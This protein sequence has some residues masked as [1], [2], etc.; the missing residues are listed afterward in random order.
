MLQNNEMLVLRNDIRM[1]ADKKQEYLLDKR[2]VF[3]LLND[4]LGVSDI[5]N[6][7]VNI[8]YD[9][10]ILDLSN[11][12]LFKKSGLKVLRG[13]QYCNR[14]KRLRKKFIKYYKKLVRLEKTFKC[15]TYNNISLNIDS[16]CFEYS[17]FFKLGFAPIHT[18]AINNIF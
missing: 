13:L 1:D 9:I 10:E 2:R 18:Q 6:E 11:E 7:I 3:K 12:I 16:I 14:S 15:M 8:V 4:I 5:S 17:N